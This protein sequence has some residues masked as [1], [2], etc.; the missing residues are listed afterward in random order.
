M[1]DIEI[2]ISVIYKGDTEYDVVD[3]EHID[4]PTVSANDNVMECI[5]YCVDRGFNVEL[6]PSRVQCTG[7]FVIEMDPKTYYNDYAIHL[8]YAKIYMN[9]L[10]SAMYRALTCYNPLTGEFYSGSGGSVFLYRR[11][12]MIGLPYIEQ[13]IRPGC[14]VHQREDIGLPVEDQE[15]L[16]IY[17]EGLARIGAV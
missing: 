8:L 6:S 10:N 15:R 13:E 9:G 12:A 5:N 16:D 1:T 2:D 14:T 7:E 17:K 3:S 11:D 4:H